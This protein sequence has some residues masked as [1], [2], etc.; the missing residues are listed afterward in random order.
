MSRRSKSNSS[1]P[2]ATFY[3]SLPSL[4]FFPV[5]STVYSNTAAFST[6]AVAREKRTLDLHAPGIAVDTAFLRAGYCNNRKYRAFY[7][8]FLYRKPKNYIKLWGWK[9][10]YFTGPSDGCHFSTPEYRSRRMSHSNLDLMLACF[11]TLWSGIA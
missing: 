3:A 9:G 10:R 11:F 1:R 5:F 2:N 4:Q 6:N 8:W 7:K